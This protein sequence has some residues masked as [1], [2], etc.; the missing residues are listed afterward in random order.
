MKKLVAV[1]FAMTM[2][3]AAGTAEAGRM[4]YS[5]T[6]GYES[7]QKGLWQVGF[8]NMLLVNYMS[9]TND[10]T[11]TTM[12]KL[13][14]A[15]MAGLTPR[16]FIIDNLSVGLSLNAFYELNED[17]TE[18]GGAETTTTASDTG[19]MGLAV[20]NYNVRIGHSLFIRPG[21]GAGYFYG[22][23]ERPNTAAGAIPGSKLESTISGPAALLDLTLQYFAGPHFSMRAGPVL[24]M[25]FGSD[26]PA[27]GKAQSYTQIDAGFTAGLA[28]SF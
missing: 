28:Y 11:N 1:M 2:L 22:T 7:I 6:K 9:S 3:A 8:D 5:G 18:A 4:V 16:Y 12:S 13:R 27:V 24:V 14:V 10:D 25:R 26:A 21:V 17:T 20:V 15:Y 19:F 23:R